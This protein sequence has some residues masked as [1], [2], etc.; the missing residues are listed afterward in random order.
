MKMS[1]DKRFYFINQRN[2]IGGNVSFHAMNKKGFT[3]NV[4]KAHKFTFAEAQRAWENARELEMPVDSDLIDAGTIRKSNID[5]LVFNVKDY[6]WCPLWVAYRNEERK[7]NNV[8]WVS[9]DGV[10]TRYCDARTYSDETKP[11]ESGLVLVPKAFADSHVEDVFEVA[12]LDIDKMVHDAGFIVPERFSQVFCR[13]V[14][15]NKNEV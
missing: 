5:E 1:R 7:G 6:H 15:K 4:R 10:S 11:T 14:T 3:T 12:D 9:R 13:D 2:I 8:Y